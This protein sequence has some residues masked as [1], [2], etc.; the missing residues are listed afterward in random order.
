[1]RLRIRPYGISKR[2]TFTRALK[3]GGGTSVSICKPVDVICTTTFSARAPGNATTTWN[4]EPSA[5]MSAGGSHTGR[6]EGM[7]NSSKKLRCLRSASSSS[8]QASAHIQDILR[9]VFI[10]SVNAACRAEVQ[11]K[12]RIARRRQFA[13]MPRRT[14]PG[15]PSRKSF[16]GRRGPEAGVRG[17]PS[18]FIKIYERGRDTPHPSLLP[19]L[20][21]KDFHDGVL[22]AIASGNRGTLCDF[23]RLRLAHQP[24]R[25]EG[26]EPLRLF[27]GLVHLCGE[28]RE[29]RDG[30]G[31]SRYHAADRIEF[32]RGAGGFDI[33]KQQIGVACAGDDARQ[34]FVYLGRIEGFEVFHSLLLVSNRNIRK[35]SDGAQER[36]RTSTNC[37]TGT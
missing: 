36:T 11:G 33:W 27:C 8:A 1:M 35:L 31:R 28:R 32:R 29:V 13:R 20:P 25:V 30:C 16:R 18:P 23:L 34:R 6:A 15:T 21:R 4:S 7:A 22:A 3:L 5:K 37:S 19:L 12:R 24:G 9:L 26:Y 14:M 10:A 2:T 17:I